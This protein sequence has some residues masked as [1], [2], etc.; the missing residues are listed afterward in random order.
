MS[1]YERK[2][3][4]YINEGFEFRWTDI[5]D[6]AWKQTFTNKIRIWK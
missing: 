2:V 4:V 1:N 6:K 3:K 5:I